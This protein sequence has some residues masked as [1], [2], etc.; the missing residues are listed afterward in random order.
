M[1][2]TNTANKRIKEGYDILNR[3]SQIRIDGVPKLRNKIK[4]EINF[5]EKCIKTEIIKEEHLVCSNLIHL[6]ALTSKLIKLQ[7]VCNAVM[8]NKTLSFE[9]GYSRKICI[10]LV[11]HGG[12]VWMKVIARNQK[13]I[14]I[15]SN[16]E[17][18]YKQKSILDQAAEFVECSKQNI[19]YYKPPNVVFFFANGVDN[20]VAKDLSKVGIKVES[21]DSGGDE[22]ICSRNAP[23]ILDYPIKDLEIIRNLAV[24]RSM[25]HLKLNL[26]VTTLIAFASAL[27]NG[28]CHY[29]FK[30]DILQ[31]HAEWERARPVKPIL[32]CL[33]EDTL[34]GQTEKERGENILKQCT[35]V[36]DR[37][38]DKLKILGKIKERSLAIFGTGESLQAV[39]V[40]ANHAFIRSAMNQGINFSV[41]L[42]E[43]RALTER[44]QLPI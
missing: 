44:K 26:G 20:C 29:S 36:E 25:P 21:N 8:S 39:T 1:D 11:L 43:A 22:N 33:F 12:S 37:P 6:E 40:T 31:K 24:I 35:I 27:T 34:G 5:L 7:N 10:D 13:A 32:D 18:S 41:F 17:G 38:T 16:G 9:D 2:V 30:S 23:D 28:G 19:L 42:H 4:Q 3:L 14:T 15:I